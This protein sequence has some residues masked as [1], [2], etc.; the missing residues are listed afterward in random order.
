MMLGWLDRVSQAGTYLSP[1]GLQPGVARSAR[2]GGRLVALQK[3]RGVPKHPSTHTPRSK[4]SERA[5]SHPER[6]EAWRVW[7][8]PSPPTH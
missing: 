1:R 4:G 8:R 7:G 6:W 2:R 3:K 5:H